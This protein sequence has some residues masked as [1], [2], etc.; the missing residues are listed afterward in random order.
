VYAG[1]IADLLV[2]APRWIV[3]ALLLTLALAAMVLSGRRG[4]ARCAVFMTGM[5]CMTVQVAVMLA[6][7]VFSGLLYHM[8]AM[9]TA[10]FMAG[11]AV[12]AA[13]RGPGLRSLHI[14]MAVSAMLV[15]AALSFLPAG[16]YAG[17]AVFLGISA[18]GGLMAGMY[19]RKAVKTAWPSR[20][21][22][23]AAL[24]YSWDL[25]GGCAGALVAG[26]FLIPLSGLAW[27]A[28]FVAAVHLS[29]AALLAGRAVRN[30]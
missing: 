10:L 21:N 15:P 14:L 2:D 6:L 26:T 30:S 19:Y 7:Q 12:G 4:A 9:L 28:A 5:S 3:P 24:Y 29:A 11:A 17:T 8:L 16:G 13:S 25:M 22:A 1:G 18:A 27:T 23:P 20:G